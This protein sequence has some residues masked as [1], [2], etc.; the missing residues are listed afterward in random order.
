MNIKKYIFSYK[1]LFISILI[2]LSILFYLTFIKGIIFLWERPAE[3]TGRTLEYHHNQLIDAGFIFVG[4]YRSFEIDH[5]LYKKEES[6]GTCKYIELEKHENLGENN[7][8]LVNFSTK[9]FK[10]P[11][12]N[13][14]SVRFSSDLADDFP[15]DNKGFE[16]NY[17]K[18]IIEQEYFLLEKH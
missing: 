17:T 16:E 4:F 14:I 13:K 8:H 12:K 9:Y 15:I 6:L 1:T 2:V 5:Y 3:Y 11:L 7:S 18:E 10:T